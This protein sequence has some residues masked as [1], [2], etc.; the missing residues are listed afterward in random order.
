MTK[1][2]QKNK[3][4]TPILGWRISWLAYFM[5]T[6]G[7]K[8]STCIRQR[9]GRISSVR[10]AEKKNKQKGSEKGQKEENDKEELGVQWSPRRSM[11][12]GFQYK[13]LVELVSKDWMAE[14]E[15][16]GGP[17]LTKT[18]MRAAF[19]MLILGCNL[20]LIPLPLQ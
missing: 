1:R 20:L 3:K 11:A 10:K 5:C 16:K 14:L 6:L 9:E 8:N 7:I 13:Y 19:H 17:R 15:E 18:E 12:Q 2:R 4:V